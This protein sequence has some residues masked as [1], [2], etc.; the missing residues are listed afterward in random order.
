MLWKQRFARGDSVVEIVEVG[1]RDGLQNEKQTLA[2]ET[3]VRYI[4][5]AVAAGLKRIEAVS[6]VHPGRV[7]QMADAEAVLAAIPRPG[8]VAYSGLVLNLRGLERAL[9]CDLDEI[10][11][12]VVATDALSQANQ[13]MSTAASLRVWEEIASAARQAGKRVT[14]TLAAAFGCPYTGLV[15]PARVA[16]LAAEATDAAPAD[17]LCL[18]DTIGAGRPSEV[19]TLFNLIR[20]RTPVKLRAHF[21]NTRNTGYANA[22]AALA[23]GVEALDA[24]T[25]GIGGCPFAPGATG[26]IATEDL[27]Y[28][29]GRPTQEI[30]ETG[31]WI[32]AQLGITAPS[33]LSRAPSHPPTP[34][35]RPTHPR[36]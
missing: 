35:P 27:C 8:D 18:A 31:R 7:P 4:E 36:A 20:Q 34:S 26:N 12:V 5:R 15:D 2:T 23:A 32:A 24:S 13:G 33:L 3:K 28:L 1:P 16:A 21:H 10:T 11:Y 22:V 9:A 19:T 25:G 6:F 17:E 14:L 29:L 30:A